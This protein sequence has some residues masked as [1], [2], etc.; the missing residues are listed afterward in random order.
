MK[1]WR[2]SVDY[3]FISLLKETVCIAIRDASRESGRLRNFREYFSG[4]FR[5]ELVKLFD[6][7]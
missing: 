3:I 4:K 7:H 2:L 1:L 5:N 6:P